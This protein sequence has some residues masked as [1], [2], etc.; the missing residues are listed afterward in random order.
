[1]AKEN[2]A[3]QE[4]KLN[5]PSSKI[6]AI[7]NLIFGE[8]IAAYNSEFDNVK[9]DISS[10]KKELEDFIDE[11]RKELNQAIDNLSTDINIR[12][13]ELEDNLADKVE[14]L[15]TKKVDKNTLGNLLITLGEKISQK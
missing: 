5:D 1:M 7:K 9:K 15:D 12:I 3:V 8:N 14:M 4:E 11:T 6:E 2:K 13:T 10:K